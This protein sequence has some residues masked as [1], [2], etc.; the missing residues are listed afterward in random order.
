MAGFAT[1]AQ[2]ISTAVAK[3]NEGGGGN[4]EVERAAIEELK[5]KLTTA[6]EELQG[7]NDPVIPA[8]AFGP[9][10]GGRYMGHHSMLAEQAA[11][12]ALVA[13][14]D[15]ITNYREAVIAA[16]E[17]Q[18]QADD[19]A[20]QDATTLALQVESSTIDLGTNYFDNDDLNTSDD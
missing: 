19:A 14:R 18:V 13:I 6:I 7:S 9:S 3:L 4:F 1:L 16:N 8:S 15:G 17:I 5:T 20:A 10:D 11:I 12:D 2:Q